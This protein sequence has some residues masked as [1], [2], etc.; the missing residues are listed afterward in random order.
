MIPIFTPVDS[1]LS[2]KPTVTITANAPIKDPMY[3][4]LPFMGETHHEKSSHYRLNDLCDEVVHHV[5][6]S[7]PYK[8]WPPPTKDSMGNKELS[9]NHRGKTS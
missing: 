9:G 4:S 8:V 1:I 2:S 5:S 7:N 6:P 3:S